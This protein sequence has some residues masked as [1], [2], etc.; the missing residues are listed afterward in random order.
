MHHPLIGNLS[1]LT[2]E[3]LQ[4]KISELNSKLS[5]AYRS[6]NNALIG[7]LQMALDSYNDAYR[8]KIDAQNKKDDRDFGS[9]IDVS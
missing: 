3:Q 9:K 8:A 4:E 5:F 2:L 6:G 7:Q 1:D